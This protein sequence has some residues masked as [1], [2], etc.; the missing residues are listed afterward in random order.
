MLN[1]KEVSIMILFIAL[2]I[3]KKCDRINIWFPQNVTGLSVCPKIQ[4]NFIKSFM[5]ADKF[6]DGFLR[7]IEL[8]IQICIF[9]VTTSM[10]KLKMIKIILSLLF[11]LAT[12]FS[13][14]ADFSL[15]GSDGEQHQLSEYVGKD[16]WVVVNVWSTACKFCRHELPDLVDFHEA[17][18]NENATVLGIVIDLE[19][20]GYPDEATV[21]TFLQDF[22]IDYPNLYASADQ[23]AEMLGA[24]I[25]S[26]PMSF[27][28]NP[29][30]KMMGHW[31]GIISR[32]Q[33]EKIIANT[34]SDHGTL[35]SGEKSRRQPHE[36]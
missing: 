15:K 5:S 35:G 8:L 29:Q 25:T 22:F 1:A 16:K 9:I 6:M 17:H 19:T 14:N 4:V 10:K 31:N 27:F 32:D 21:K 7:S 3:M 11:L 30:G 13:V 23:A 34:S 24:P 2:V 20:F 18:A 26:I 12:S 33:L 28:F 36:D